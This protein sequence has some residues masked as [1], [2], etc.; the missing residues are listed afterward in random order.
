MLI[1]VDLSFFGVKRSVSNSL[2]LQLEC[3]VLRPCYVCDPNQNV[4]Q[5]LSEY[6]EIDVVSA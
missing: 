6:C 3:F 1:S 4:S 2:F 5:T